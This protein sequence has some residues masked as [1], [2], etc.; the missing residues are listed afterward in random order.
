MRLS[1]G[2][3]SPA[4]VA[5][6]DYD[7]D[8]Q[9]VG[10]VHFGIGAFHRAHQAA[11]TDAAMCGGDRD[12]L[13]QGVSMRSEKVAE[14]LNPQGG[15]YSLTERQGAT[16]STRIIGAVTSVLVAPKS[17]ESVVAALSQASV[18]LVSFTITEK[19]YRRADDGGFPGF[20]DLLAQGF[21]LRMT[22]GLPGLTLM[23]CDNLPHNGQVLQKLML[24]NAQVHAPAL[25]RWIEAEC[26]FPSSM[27]DRIVPATTPH[28]LDQLE[29]TLGVRDEGA[30]LT[31][32]FSQWVIEDRFMGRRPRWERHGVQ[33]VADVAPYETA[34][35]RMLNGAHSALAYLGLERG[36]TFVH[37][38]ICDSVIGPL[39]ERLMRV[40]A[41]TSFTPSPGQDLDAYADALLQRFRNP[42]LNHRL[43]QIAMDGSQK[44]PQ[45]WLATLAAHQ[46]QHTP[47][48]TLLIALVAWMRHV[49]GDVRPVEDPM[50]ETLA[51]AWRACGQD[52]IAIALFGPSGLFR[53]HWIADGKTLAQLTDL[54]TSRA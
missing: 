45:R 5:L 27:V 18:S 21:A 36:C 52:Q 50:A 48:P 42:A 19:G 34:K 3:A 9:Q 6:P 17:P 53:T 35:L 31:E 32:P 44:I 26:A 14:A 20:C 25:S 4:G 12:F 15:L 28:D 33:I 37:E 41:A 22:L 8:A 13:I 51:D 7:R 11:F 38:A 1:P 49:R 54:I 43:A 16:A 46:A 39:V 23:A 30:V 29:Q 47:C 10:I 40:E 24:D 2:F